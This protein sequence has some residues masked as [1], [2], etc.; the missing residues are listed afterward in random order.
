MQE[1]TYTHFHIYAYRDVFSF[2]TIL[3]SKN[4]SG[5]TWKGIVDSADGSLPIEPLKTIF[6]IAFSEKGKLFLKLKYSFLTRI[7]QD[8]I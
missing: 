4:Y 5:S 1:Y 6:E 2:Y 8:Y 3:I 7:I